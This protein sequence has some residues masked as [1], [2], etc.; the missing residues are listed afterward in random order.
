MLRQVEL[1]GTTGSCKF[2]LDDDKCI[3]FALEMHE[4][5]LIKMPQQ[6]RITDLK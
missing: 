3:A 5:Q 6:K 2:E 4:E 1:S